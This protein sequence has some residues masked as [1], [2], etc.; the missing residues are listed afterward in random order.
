[1]RRENME[2]STAGTKIKKY[3]ASNFSLFL[4]SPQGCYSE[5]QCI[6]YL[7][8]QTPYTYNPFT[9]PY[10]VMRTIMIVNTKE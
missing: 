4:L 2:R 6:N 1:M 8:D 9:A 7:I 10:G 5:K 3:K